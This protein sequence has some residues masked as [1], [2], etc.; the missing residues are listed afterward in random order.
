M[1]NERI[2]EFFLEQALLDELPPEKKQILDSEEAAARLKELELSNREILMKYDPANMT[3]QILK[4]LDSSELESERSNIKTGWFSEHRVGVILAAAAVA[5]FTLASPFLF[6]QSPSIDTA[7]P[8][9]EF[10]RIKGMDPA[11]MLYRNH[12]GTVEQLVDGAT[13]RESDLIQ[14]SYNAAGKIFGAIFSI[15]GSGVVSLHFPGDTNGSL[16]LK[17]EGEIALDFSYRLDDA[18]R[19]EQFFF[20]TSDRTFDMA[21][22]LKAAENLL[23]RLML[24]KADPGDEM[25]VLPDGLDYTS[26]IIRKEVSK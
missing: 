2:P 3:E 15:D 14:I 20:V 23:E 18:P 13:A 9:T 26:L 1:K 19:F 4:R 11:I 8:G 5:V 22:V 24:K 6:R 17:R 21:A 7:T 12:D 16:V 25:L 10:T